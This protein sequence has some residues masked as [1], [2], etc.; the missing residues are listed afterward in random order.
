MGLDLCL[1]GICAA[2]YYYMD[3]GNLGLTI[4]VFH[5]VNE[6]AEIDLA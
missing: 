1:F 3:E 5:N 6:L 4:L 2:V